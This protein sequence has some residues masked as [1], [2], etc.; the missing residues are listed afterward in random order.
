MSVG[1][2]VAIAA[3]SYTT[4]PP[5]DRVWVLAEP[6]THG[7]PIA[8]MVLVTPLM[9]ITTPNAKITAP[10]TVSRIGQSFRM[11]PTVPP[12]DG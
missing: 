11:P 7:V 10:T 6:A 9:T 5:C 3:R 2:S 4:Y 8:L 12:V 1:P